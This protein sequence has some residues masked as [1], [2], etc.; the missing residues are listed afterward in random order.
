VLEARE[1]G[2]C[3]RSAHE[4]GKE[5]TVLLRGERFGKNISDHEVGR[6][7]CERDVVLRDALADAVEA[8]THVAG[9]GPGA[10]LAV[11]GQADGGRVVD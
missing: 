6:A 10:G 1:E 4:G 9:L 11:G 7:E 3:T 5:A 2:L 8:D